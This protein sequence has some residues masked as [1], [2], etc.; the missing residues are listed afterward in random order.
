[1]FRPAAIL[2]LDEL[3]AGTDPGTKEMEKC[4]AV[5][6]SCQTT[7]KDRSGTCAATVA[8]DSGCKNTVLW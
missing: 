5:Q 4:P 2:V 3:T 6:L 1:M 7:D 8:Y